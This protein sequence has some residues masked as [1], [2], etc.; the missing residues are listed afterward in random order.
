[1]LKKSITLSLSFILFSLL[2]TGF[3]VDTKKIDT[4]KLCK[5]WYITSGVMKSG[6]YEEQLPEDIVNGKMIFYKNFTVKFIDPIDKDEVENS[7]CPNF[8]VRM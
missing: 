1:M 4:D 6:D 8:S 7:N 5:T 2:S 3:T